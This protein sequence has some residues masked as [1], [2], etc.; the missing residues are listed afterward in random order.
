[1]PDLTPSSGQA[2]PHEAGYMLDGLAAFREQRVV[3]SVSIVGAT[4]AWPK[5]VGPVFLRHR[6]ARPPGLNAGHAG[7]PMGQKE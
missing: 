2:R 3:G 6:P 4:H 7:L 1:M 5:A